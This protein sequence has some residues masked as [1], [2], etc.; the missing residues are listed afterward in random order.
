MGYLHFPNTAKAKERKGRSGARSQATVK[1]RIKVWQ[2]IWLL[3]FGRVS[4]NLLIMVVEAGQEMEGP[5]GRSLRVRVLIVG[6]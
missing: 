6:R 1:K 4:E 5:S 3:L 2:A